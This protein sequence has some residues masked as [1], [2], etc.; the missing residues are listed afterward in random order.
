MRIN[1]IRG[2]LSSARINRYLIATGNNNSK[3]IKLYK[4]NLKISQSFLPILSILEVVIRNKTN[5]ILTS[6][7]TDSDW[8]INQKKWL[9]VTSFINVS[10]SID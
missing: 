10:S 3:A 5:T 4:H 6:Y 8:I 2:H 7:F 9:Y 1:K